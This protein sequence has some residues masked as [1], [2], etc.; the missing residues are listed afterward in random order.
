MSSIPLNTQILSLK[1]LKAL[2]ELEACGSLLD[3]A[4]R[5][6]ITL[7]ALSQQI[8]QIETHYQCTL[9]VR[10]SKPI[11]FS[12]QGKTLLRLAEQVLPLFNETHAQLATQND[13]P[14]A[15]TLHIALECHSCYQWLLPDHQ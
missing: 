15:P 4:N 7:P 1:I 6:N 11:K 12:E 10:K 2:K 3:T 9:F 14:E 5:L 13:A 8:K